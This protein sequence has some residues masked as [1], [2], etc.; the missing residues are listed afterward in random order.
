MHSEKADA[1][2]STEGDIQIVD[3]N[4]SYEPSKK[5]QWQQWI[6]RC[7]QAGRTKQ[8]RVVLRFTEYISQWIHMWAEGEGWP[9]EVLLQYFIDDMVESTADLWRETRFSG[10]D[11]EQVKQGCLR[12][13][14]FFEE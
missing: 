8:F 9:V 12:I 5:V 6:N 3:L 2:S 4:L 10:L 1:L 7:H 14:P 11:F 13:E